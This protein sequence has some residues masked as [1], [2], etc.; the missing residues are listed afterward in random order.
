MTTL[1]KSLFSKIVDLN[2]FKFRDLLA[3]DNGVYENNGQPKNYYSIENLDD[4]SIRYYNKIEKGKFNNKLD[5]IY[6]KVTKYHYYHK[7]DCTFARK[8]IRFSNDSTDFDKCLL[9]YFHTGTP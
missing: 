2:T 6:F 7:L 8:I 5:D 4:K 9:I 1:P 3:D